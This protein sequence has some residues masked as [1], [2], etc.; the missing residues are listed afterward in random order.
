MFITVIAT[1]LTLGCVGP[2]VAGNQPRQLPT[3][4]PTKSSVPTSTPSAATAQG[5]IDGLANLKDAV[6]IVGGVVGLVGGL[7][8][9]WSALHPPKITV[10]HT[11]HIGVVVSAD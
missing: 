10:A 8:G 9:M 2:Q 5:E 11:D 4:S 7:M 6:A 1:L 3:A